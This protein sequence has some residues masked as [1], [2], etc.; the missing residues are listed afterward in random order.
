MKF[1]K[2]KGVLSAALLMSVSLS[3]QAP[4]HDK[5]IKF[6]ENLNFTEQ[7]PKWSTEKPILIPGEEE[8]EE[9]FISRVRRKSRFVNVNTQVDPGMDPARKMIWWCPIGISAWN[10]LPSYRFDSEVFSMWSY[11]D[12]Y[13][14]WTAPLVRMPGAFSDICHKNGI[15]T[16]VLGSVPFAEN[17]FEGDSSWGDLLDAIYSGGSEKFLKYLRYY[18]IDGFGLNSEFN[19]SESLNVKSKE[20][21]R[22]L[23]RKKNDIWPNFSNVWYAW[24]NNSGR[25]GCSLELNS[26][27]DD[28]FQWEGEQT[29]DYFFLN[30]GWNR[31]NLQNSQSNAEELGRSSYDVYAGF[32]YEGGAPGKWGALKDSKISVGLWGAHDMNLI[33]EDRGELGADVRIKQKAYQL[34]S[35][36]S[37]TG[38]TYNPV[39]PPAIRDYLS[40]S[41]L[42]TD[43]HGISSFVTARSPLITDDLAK[44]P[45]V[46]YFNLGNGFFFNVKGEREFNGEWYNIGIQDYLPTWRWWW[47]SK[48]MGR[49]DTDVPEEGL[50]AEFTWDDAWFGG[51]CLSIYGKTT[52][53]Y[54]QLFKTEY[55]L[56]TG[57]KFTIRYKVLSGSGDL[58]WSYCE[59]DNESRA[60][61][62]KIASLA[63]TDGK[64]VENTIEVGTGLKNIRMNGKTLAML[65][66]R[67]EKTTSVFKILIGEVSITRGE[68]TTPEKPQIVNQKALK[69]TYN[70]V[71]FKVIYKMKD[72]ENA[73][74]VYNDEVGTWYYKIY[75]QQKGENPVM[76]TA[77][78]GW[79]SYVVGAPLN[80]S[81]EHRFRIG[82]SAVGIDGKNESDIA[83]SDYMDV[84]E[85]EIVEGISLDKPVIKPNEEFSIGFNDPN[86]V[87]AEWSIYRSSDEVQV[88]E[89]KVGTRI[90]LSLPEIGMYNVHYTTQIGGKDTAVIHNGMIQ[91]SSEEVGA[92]PRIDALQV[93]GSDTEVS[94]G[95]YTPVTYT[96][97]GREADGYVSRGLSL[98]EKAFGLDAGQLNFTDRSAFTFC[99]WFNPVR[100]NPGKE[101]TNLFCIRN[102]Y[103]GWSAS[104]WGYTWFDISPTQE[105]VYLS[106][107]SNS[108]WAPSPILHIGDKV[109]F[110]TNQWHHVAIVYDYNEGRDVTIYV[111]GKNVGEM[112]GRTSL[113]NW[114]Q[115]N[116]IMIGGAA[117]NRAGLDATIDEVQLYNKAL[118]ADEVVNSMQHQVNPSSALIGYWDF[119]TDADGSYMMASTG[120]DKSLVASIL[121]QRGG[122]GADKFIP[123]AAHYGAGA[124]FISGTNFK[125]ET[126]PEWK[127]D[128]IASV[129]S[130]EGNTSA[131]KAVVEYPAAA[132]YQATL[133]L[134]NSWGS[135][136]KTFPFVKIDDDGT[137]MED[138]TIGNISAYPNPFVDELNLQLVHAGTYSIQ[139]YT[140]DGK[141]VSQRNVSAQDG[142]F[143]CVRIYAEP[144]IYIVN[145]KNDAGKSVGNIR[146]IKKD[147]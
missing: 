95:T 15:G 135:D 86:H 108:D 73:M 66:F 47:T 52:E 90:T 36:N 75:F 74:P 4:L 54:L 131:G 61:A 60:R 5:Y 34:I 98:Q 70:T 24:M 42:E 105:E 106:M 11:I 88:G 115:N 146:V 89:S 136:T 112:K 109:N 122:E 6:K 124:P 137:G 71:D 58:F 31:N 41:S 120:S 132:T 85:M 17:V 35:E 111:N 32:N 96:Y 14:N 72:S 93:N 25:T 67:F 44:E 33:F 110:V 101:G 118:T 43:N 116:R 39:N 114:S 127:F 55:P 1:S 126:L 80:Y 53:E 56:Q 94:S 69:A 142:D 97:I 22:E 10:G 81:S 8:D 139:V 19:F 102:P 62:N 84:P 3:A 100:Y 141:M 12:H 140:M 46:T 45:F 119:E 48:F 107:R 103:D 82:V 7:Y 113:Y 123:D 129:T 87:A 138:T 21:F 76:C 50:K 78:T 59:K 2:F 57:D 18:G 38:S 92:M 20:F 133:T 128:D 99:F 68:A 79:A 144:G 26:G 65:G 83:W 117:A 121:D 77:T 29:S 134:S 23:F 51:S 64:W 16:S 125:V 63:S 13:G 49:E 91:I 27:N 30:Y 40:H 130:A 143:V 104:D 37:F 147:Q 145:V 28:W 9:F